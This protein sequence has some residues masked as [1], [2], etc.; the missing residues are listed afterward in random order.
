MRDTILM[1]ASV[2]AALGVAFT[3][4][5]AEL[6]PAALVAV[7]LHAYVVPSTSP[8]TV[9]GCDARDALKLPPPTQVAV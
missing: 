4:A 3:V 8:V 6:T 2:A 1:S 9:I 5:D 7:T